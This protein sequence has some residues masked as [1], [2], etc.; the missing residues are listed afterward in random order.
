MKMRKLLSAA[1]VAAALCLLS[2]SCS[3]RQYHSYDGAVWG[4]TFHIVYESDRELADSVMAQ[5]RRVEM[6]LSAFEPSSTVS[7]INSG[8]DARVD[9]LFERVFDEACGGNRLSNGMFDPT[10]GP[11]VDIW[12][13]G[14][15]SGVSAEPD[16]AAVSV[17]LKGVGISR[18]RI[19]NG[20]LVKAD[21][22]TQF[23]FSAIAKGLGVDCVAEML[24]RNGCA[25][26]M[27]EIGGE[28]A[29]L[30]VNAKGDVWRI[31]IDAPIDDASGTVHSQLSV[32]SLADR[33][34]ATSGNYRNYRD[35]AS[36]RVGHT[37]SPITGQPVSTATLSAS[38]CAP[39]CM[40]ADA[41]ATACMAMPADEALKMIESQNEVEALIVVAQPGGY[42]VLTT[43]HFPR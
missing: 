8:A 10:V 18:C 30:G 42:R 16:S 25:N 36:G 33:A 39:S 37:I 7:V 43:A 40:T 19:D 28:V 32:I 22:T 35:Y 21:S 17:A 2:L 15:K 29:A 4:T 31:Q 23:D 24:R 34:I 26:Y 9:E 27:V 1:T 12:G 20:L 6:S 41:L 11:L 13:F 14:R 5:I 3:D 38:V